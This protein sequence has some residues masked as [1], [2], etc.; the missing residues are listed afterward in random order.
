MQTKMYEMYHKTNHLKVFN[1]KKNQGY[2]S[3]TNFVALF[4][5]AEYKAKNSSTDI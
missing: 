4:I 2:F 3:T 5:Q 1:N